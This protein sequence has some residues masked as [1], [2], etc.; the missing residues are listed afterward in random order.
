[1]TRYVR[2]VTDVNDVNNVSSPVRAHALGEEAATTAVA[3]LVDDAASPSRRRRCEPIL[4]G[5][6][7]SSD[8]PQPD[9]LTGAA[10]LSPFI[11]PLTFLPACCPVLSFLSYVVGAFLESTE[12][13]TSITCKRRQSPASKGFGGTSLT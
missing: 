8:R 3:A 1:L 4:K 9:G 10:W 6:G 2:S 5:C 13:G 7:S 11:A 12:T